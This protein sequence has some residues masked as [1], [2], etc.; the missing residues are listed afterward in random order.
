MFWFAIYMLLGLLFG[1][2]SIRAWKRMHRGPMDAFIWWLCVVTWPLWLIMIA[3]ATWIRRK[4]SNSD[5]E[6]GPS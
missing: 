5:R 2:L 3:R 1:E 6:G 4:A